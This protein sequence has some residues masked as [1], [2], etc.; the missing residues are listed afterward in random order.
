MGLKQNIKNFF[1]SGVDNN[2]GAGGTKIRI[3]MVNGTGN[4]TY[5]WNNKIYKSDIIRSCI[6]PKASAVGKMTAKHIRDDGHSEM[7]INPDPYMRFLLEEPNPYMSGQL[8]QERLVTTLMLNNNAFALIVRND[9]GIPTDIYP[10]PSSSVE[11]VYDKSNQLYLKFQYRNGK[12]GTYPYTDI[13]H[14]RQDYGYND[15]DIFGHNPSDALTP[16]ME[17]MGTT[18][19]GIVNSIKNSG[20]IKWLMKFSNSMRPEDIKKQVEEFTKNYLSLDSDSLGVAGIDPKA[21]VTQVTPHDLMPNSPVIN[22]ITKRAYSF[23]HTNEKI[24][25]S[26]YNEDEWNSYYESEIEP[27]GIQLSNEFTRKLFSRRERGFGNKIVFEASNLQYASMNT[28]LRLTQFVDR[29]MMTPNEV[30][31]LLNLTPIPGGD[32]PIRRLDTAPIKDVD[33]AYEPVEAKPNEGGEE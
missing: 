15:N 2:G 4:G 17:I 29:G 22:Y 16:L 5:F 18:D 19:K 31:K 23:F 26:S 12:S 1:N 7:K 9:D 6:R 10:I 3:E 24:I 21:D 25:M 33:N 20:T 11:A 8:L 28:K 27:I 14:L 32:T 30:R 13:I